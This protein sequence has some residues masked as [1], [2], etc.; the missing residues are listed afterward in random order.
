MI[1][2]I[3]C[4]GLEGHFDVV[5]LLDNTNK[6]LKKWF[7]KKTGCDYDMIIK[8]FYEESAI[9]HDYDEE[10]EQCHQKCLKQ[11]CK[12]A[13]E[14]DNFDNN[15]C[16]SKVIKLKVFLF[17]LNLVGIRTFY[18][19]DFLYMCQGHLTYNILKYVDIVKKYD[20]THSCDF[21][22]FFDK[23]LTTWKADFEYLKK[24]GYSS[25]YKGIRRGLDFDIL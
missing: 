9:A 24:F 14:I 13:D 11:F 4:F 22:H 3:D 5:S 19:I 6:H 17:L 7:K 23:P 20:Y 25:T 12:R 8:R 21:L 10:I 1:K 15:I 2:I 18:N 16:L